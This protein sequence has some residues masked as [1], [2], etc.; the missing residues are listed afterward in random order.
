M[1]ERLSLPN[2]KSNMWSSQVHLKIKIYVDIISLFVVI[3]LRASTGWLLCKHSSLFLS[4]E[5][6]YTLIF[7]II[8]CIFF[9]TYLLRN[10]HNEPKFY[11]IFFAL[12]TEKSK[13]FWWQAWMVTIQYQTESHLCESSWKHKG[14][15][16]GQYSGC[17][18]NSQ[19]F[20]KDCREFRSVGIHLV[21]LS[22]SGFIETINFHPK[23][24]CLLQKWSL[25][26]S[27]FQQSIL[28]DNSSN[29]L[30]IQRLHEFSF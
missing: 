20:G 25:L 3:I 28:M 12:L 11:L 24:V 5:D 16:S 27:D 9:F 22:E 2:Y 21:V 29:I 26:F 6:D 1:T 13:C 17:L 19:G 15:R 18:K 4:H 30:L 7:C 10:K 8:F 14:E 23:Q